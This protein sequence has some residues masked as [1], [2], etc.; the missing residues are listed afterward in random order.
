MK[1]YDHEHPLKVIIHL[2]V[3]QVHDFGEV[4]LNMITCGQ[5]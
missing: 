2:Q 4:I 1:D 3:L 5:T